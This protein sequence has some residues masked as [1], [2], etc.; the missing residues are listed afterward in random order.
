M[1]SI[2][3]EDCECCQNLLSTVVEICKLIN[4]FPISDFKGDE[5]PAYNN[6]KPNTFEISNMR[7][8]LSLPNTSSSNGNQDVP[9]LDQ[10]IGA[11]INYQ[12]GT[13]IM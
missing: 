8:H 13:K 4:L 12:L 5:N 6:M 10:N 7:S 11:M 9:M 2:Q 1:A 3:T